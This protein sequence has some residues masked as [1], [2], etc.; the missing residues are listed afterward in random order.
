MITALAGLRQGIIT[1][2]TTQF[3]GG[4]HSL[5]RDKFHC[6]KKEGHGTM[7][8]ETALEQSCDVFFYKMAVDLG[9]DALSNVAKEFGFNS[10]TGIEIEE[11]TGF[12]PTKEWK[13]ASFGSKWQAGESIVASIGQG[14]ITVTPLQNAV[15]T[16]R[17]VNGGY[18]VTPHVIQCVGKECHID[19]DITQFQKL[20]FPPEHLALIQRGMQRVT[21]SERGTAYSKRIKD[22]GFEMGGKT[23]TSQVKRIT[24]S[25]RRLGVKNED[26]DWKY[27]HHALFVGYAPIARP[28]YVCSV[29]V[30]HGNSGSAAAAPIARD[31]LLE[32][33]KRDPAKHFS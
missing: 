8:L 1:E 30:E 5:G 2:H 17:M 19:K 6:W 9:I 21:M 25:E 7:N 10:L 11:E 13:M 33:Q 20:N 31:I 29:I 24:K 16:A 27:R 26:L 23:G 14:Y 4:S 28:R 18:A 3:C 15:M 12:I 32:V 22:V